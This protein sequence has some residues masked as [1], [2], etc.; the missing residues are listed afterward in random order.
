MSDK[1]KFEASFSV[2]IAH[3]GVRPPST[4]QSATGQSPLASS[5][6]TQR[7]RFELSPAALHGGGAG[8]YRVR[9]NRRWYDGPDGEPMFL[10]REGIAQLLVDISLQVLEPLPPAPEDF[11]KYKRCSVRL[12]RGSSEYT[13]QCIVWSAPIR[14]FDGQFYVL[15]SVYGV[16]RIFVPASNI[17]VRI[18]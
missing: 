16:G 7:V 13:T 4:P 10:S 2:R 15:V 11:R 18:P 8:L 17:I 1:R 5:I 12:Q 14:A 3:G 6:G 9:V